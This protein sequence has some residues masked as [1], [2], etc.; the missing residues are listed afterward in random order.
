MRTLHT[1]ARYPAGAAAIKAAG[2][3]NTLEV[4]IAAGW[5]PEPALM[6]AREMILDARREQRLAD[7]AAAAAMQPA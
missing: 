1:L 6:L 2:V 4:G 7:E 3:I 5:I